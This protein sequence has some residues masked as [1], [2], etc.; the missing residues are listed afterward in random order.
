MGDRPGN[1]AVQN[2]DLLIT[3]G[4]RLNIYQVG[5]DVNL[6]AREAFVVAN[7]I[8]ADELRK[9]TI[10]VDLPVCA[11]ASDFMRALLEANDLTPVDEKTNWVEQCITWKKHYPVVTDIQKNQEGLANVYAFIDTLSRMLP[12]NATT[13]VA[14]GSASVV[15]SA[16]YYIKD[17]DRFI[18]N[19]AL[20]SM[21]YDL[22][23]AIGACVANDRKPTVCLAGDGSIMMNL[24][25]LQTIVT[26]KLPIKVFV[27][28]N[29]G[30]HQA[31]LTQNNL[32][33][34]GLVGVG[35]ESGDLEFPDFSKI[36][37]AFGM[38]YVGIHS[39]AETAEGVQRVLDMDGFVLAEVF[40]DT[41]Q[42]FEP[43]SASK[44]LPDGTMVSPPLEDL[45]PFIPREE[46]AE[47]MYIPMMEE[48][49]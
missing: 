8:D 31:R 40:V 16:T 29:A 43:K 46:L 3:I 33:K 2:S 42:R 9:P 45:A 39:N 28:N 35:P 17:N 20:S 26:N 23:A 10:R 15:G 30:Y 37:D 14:N 38:P 19:C 47:N 4:S 18:M 1:F 22:P 6:W 34:N 32:F 25:E 48:N 41:V 27:I 13:V 44:R 7:D 36:A 49:H 21:G 11:D 5:F 12:E 24:Q